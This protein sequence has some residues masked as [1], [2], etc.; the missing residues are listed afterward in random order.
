MGGIP[1]G[2]ALNEKAGQLGAPFLF[3]PYLIISYLSYDFVFFYVF[4][5]MKK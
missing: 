2:F 4:S 5:N 1:A 3:F